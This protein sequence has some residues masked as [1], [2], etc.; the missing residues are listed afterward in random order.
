VNLLKNKK[1]RKYLKDKIFLLDAERVYQLKPKTNIRSINEHDIH[2]LQVQVDTFR[3]VLRYLNDSE[4]KK[5]SKKEV[6][7]LI[8]SESKRINKKKH[9]LLDNEDANLP[10]EFNEVDVIESQINLLEVISELINIKVK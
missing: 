3:E 5:E 7:D 8:E 9:E 4:K 1:L 2:T 10:C 6:L